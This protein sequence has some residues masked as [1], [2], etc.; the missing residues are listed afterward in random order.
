M[1]K[2]LISTTSPNEFNTKKVKEFI[3][4][5]R[6][7]LVSGIALSVKDFSEEKVGMMGGRKGISVDNLTIYTGED[8]V[9]NLSKV[10][11]MNGETNVTMWDTDECNEIKGTG[12]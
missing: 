5:Y 12:K 4:G 7:G 10:Y 6:D 11:A 8:M 9:E 3:W 1:L 2:T